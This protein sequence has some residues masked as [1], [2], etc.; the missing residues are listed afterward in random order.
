MRKGVLFAL[1]WFAAVLPIL[2]SVESTG[3]AQTPAPQA[4]GHPDPSLG[5]PTS[6]QHAQTP[7]PQAAGHPDPSLGKPTSGQH[8]QV[9]RA[10][11]IPAGYR[12]LSSKEGQAIAQGIAWADD[13][14]GLAPDCSH[15]VHT[16]YQ[17]AGYPYPYVTSI[18]LYR[19]TG[20]FLRVRTAQ[21]GDLIVWQGHVGIVVNP[22]EHSFFSSVTPGTRTQ[23]YLSPYWRTR[24]SPRFYRYLTKSTA[25]GSVGTVEAAGRSEPPA[26]QQA[27][28]SGTEPQ[29]SLRVVKTPSATTASRVRGEDTLD[30]S[31]AENSL[32][33]PSAPILIRTVG[34]QPKAGEVTAA[35]ETANL[36]AGEM[37]RAGNLE[38][39]ERP[40][41]VYRQLQVSGVEL[42]GKRGTAQIRVE[43][44]AALTA[45]R[46]AAQ[47]GW[48]DHQLALER[49]KKGWTMV[50]GNEIAYVPRDAAMRVLAERLA[51]LTQS[52]ERSTQKDRE[53]AEIVR[54]MNLLIQ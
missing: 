17:H 3:Q 28:A 30:K 48:E 35:L 46:M 1:L 45:D 53:Q 38:K 15:L 18:D 11:A 37:L 14:E 7:A 21:P 52:T 22:R 36:E 20:S 16:L 2:V 47:L 23:D 39:L 10:P 29:P 41:V 19:G 13:E 5:K 25:K 9:S 43:T 31:R 51:A 40:V 34:S 49:T 6:G 32:Q 33:T 26:K 50:E 12:V 27:V 54:F 8:A 44:L 24:G 4:A 42:N